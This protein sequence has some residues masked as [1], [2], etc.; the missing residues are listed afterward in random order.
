[1]A[2]TSAVAEQTTPPAAEPGQQPEP[3]DNVALE[4]ALQAALTADEAA[5]AVSEQAATTQ[6]AA[7]QSID[8]ARTAVDNA[9]GAAKSAWAEFNTR[10]A[11]R[12]K[13][14]PA[15]PLMLLILTL[16]I[17]AVG[18]GQPHSSQ[19]NGIVRHSVSFSGEHLGAEVESLDAIA[20][21]LD[22]RLLQQA[23]ALNGLALAI[24]NNTDAVVKLAEQ[25][26]AAD[27]P[28]PAAVVA[29][30][31]I[32]PGPSAVEGP[33]LRELQAPPAKPAKPKPRCC[34]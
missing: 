7:Q 15:A 29:P 26:S 16:S 14:S 25:L 10:L 3:A 19:T 5:I 31:A 22:V 13:R 23:E 17:L 27:C 34:P 30:P 18:C 20:N 1:M 32:L 24:G 8:A 6:A 21:T 12:L 9:K 33:L 11:D 28:R 4:F 2:K